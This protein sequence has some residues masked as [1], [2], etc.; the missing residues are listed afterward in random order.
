M[1]AR[2]LL[3]VLFIFTFGICPFYGIADDYDWPRWRGPNG[4]GISMETDWNPKALI[5][6]PN[7]LWKADVGFGHSNVAI[8]DNRLC[9]MGMG[10]VYCFDT[11]TGEEIWL[12]PL[13][14]T[15][16]TLATPTTDGKYVYTLDKEGI[17]LCLKAKNGKVRWK[18]D[19]VSEYDVTRPFYGFAA[20]P[21]IEGDL[22]IL[23]ANTSGL[24]LNKKTGKK[25]WGSEKPP[26]SISSFCETTGVD[27][28][29]PV[30]YEYESKRYAILSSYEGMHAVD[31]ET[32]EVLWLYEWDCYCRQIPD[33]LIFDNKVLISG[34][35]FNEVEWGIVLLDISRKDPKVLWKSLNLY[36][37]IS[38]PVLV[39]GYI[40]GCEGGPDA[41][42]CSLRCLDV[43]TGE[44]MWEEDLRLENE[45]RPVTVSLIAADGKLIILEDDGTLHIAKATPTS[46]QEISS[47]DMLEGEQKM[48]Q[49]W[50][51][52]VLCNGKIYC[53]NFAGDLI[54]IDVSK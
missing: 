30:L 6:D 46:Y 25:V 11:D 17:L 52:P 49:F 13:D 24:V 4:D 23:T 2:T 29:T 32:G 15:N 31:V 48:R 14:S 51:P 12:H 35:F 22:L 36:S 44:I 19:L 41:A 33:P 1:K 43:K 3:C 40:Y 26:E 28:S 34:M 9:T 18:K 47:G 16:D 37:K 5:G 27:F 10:G 53:R 42:P 54:C 20:S 39:D 38:S 45:R 7:I 8:K 21:V 50:I